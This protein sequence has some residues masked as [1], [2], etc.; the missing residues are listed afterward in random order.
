MPAA[1][2]TRVCCWCTATLLEY[3]ATICVL[4][5]EAKREMASHQ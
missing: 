1:A 5:A 2:I 3:A 4:Y